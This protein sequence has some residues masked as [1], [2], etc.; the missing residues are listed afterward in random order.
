MKYLDI[1]FPTPQHNLACDEALVHWC[2]GSSSSDEIL[3][4]WQPP[5]YF[6]VLGHSSKIDSDIDVPSCQANRIP[7]FRR[8][9]GGGTVLQGPGCLDYSLILRIDHRGPLQGISQTNSFV[10]ESLKRALEP[11]IGPG[12]EIQGQSDLAFGTRK[13]SGN[14]QY[15][16]RRFLLFH[17]TFLLDFDI[18]L[19]DRLLAIPS[20]QP[21][22]R[23]NRSHGD[24]VTNLHL[25]PGRVKE[26]LKQAWGAAEELKDLSLESIERLVRERY[27]KE[28]WNAKF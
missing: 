10:L 20:K 12:V 22:Y 3:R 18:P 27:G 4:F 28:E 16:K 5:D 21:P 19:M 23:Q 11:L 17:G 14:A 26:A 9:S 24:F 7:I 8:C 6:V 13:F 2:E 1:T 25:P 15:R